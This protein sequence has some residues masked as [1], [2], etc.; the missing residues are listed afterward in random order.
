MAFTFTDENFE[1]ETKTWISL[2]DFWAPWCGPCQMLWPVIEQ[3]ATE[4]EWKAKIW[5]IN[6][7][8]QQWTAEKYQ[9]MGI[10]AIKIF[11]DWELV[12]EITGFVPADTIKQAID[13]HL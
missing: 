10:P 11:K 8:E 4:Y 2:V 6:V 13:K 5:K 3:I 12:E 9:V 1:E 7:D